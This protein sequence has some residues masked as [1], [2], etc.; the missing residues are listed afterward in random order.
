ME[1]PI[2]FSSPLVNQILMDRKTQTRRVVT[3]DIPSDADEVF[4]WPSCGP[5]EHHTNPGVWARRHNSD[6][7]ATDGW[8]RHLGRN[9]YGWVGDSLWVRETWSPDHAAFYPHHP[10]VYKA[11]Y[12]IEIEDGHVFSPEANKRFPFKWRPSIHMPRLHCRL[13]LAVTEVRIERLQAITSADAMDEGVAGL[14]IEAMSAV[15]AFSRYWDMLNGKRGYPW[16]DNPWVWVV[17]FE[18]IVNGQG[19]ARTPQDE[20]AASQ[21]G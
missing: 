7:E 19:T 2:L 16:K 5:M 17:T 9:P 21:A 12:P 10:I 14:P 11:D 1:R 8:I 3:S 13:T 4:V 20:I 15:G 6:D 18:R